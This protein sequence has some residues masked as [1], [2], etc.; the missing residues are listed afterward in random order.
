[1]ERRD[2]GLQLASALVCSTRK[3]LRIPFASPG[4]QR[5]RRRTAAA[6]A[7]RHSSVM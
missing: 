7:L 3:V 4:A 6:A 1:M 2:T 5:R